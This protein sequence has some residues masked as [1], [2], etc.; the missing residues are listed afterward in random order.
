MAKFADRGPPTNIG[1]FSL[2]LIHY[3]FHNEFYYEFHYELHYELHFANS[4]SL[5]G[6]MNRLSTV[7]W[8]VQLS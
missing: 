8:L 1:Y 3:G 7:K 5:I 6:S 2:K 4:N